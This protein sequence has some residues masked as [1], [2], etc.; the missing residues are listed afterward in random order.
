ML[1]KKAHVVCKDYNCWIFHSLYDHTQLQWE[2][3][4][5]IGSIDVD[6]K[7]SLNRKIRDVPR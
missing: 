1:D 4:L 7:L 5:R 2:E 3:I 6:V